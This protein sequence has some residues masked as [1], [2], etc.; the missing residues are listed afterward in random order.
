MLRGPF[1]CATW[2][3]RQAGCALSWLQKLLVPCFRNLSALQPGFW[4]DYHQIP[5]LHTHAPRRIWPMMAPSRQNRMTEWTGWWL[6]FGPGGPRMYICLLWWMLYL[7]YRTQLRP[8]APVRTRPRC[9]TPGQLGPGASLS[10]PRS[11][12]SFPNTA[13]PPTH[14]VALILLFLRQH[15]T[16]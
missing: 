1:A 13:L 11:E 9:V 7:P 6:T 15:P 10:P 4:Y 8:Q 12:R 14:V 3:A 16:Q 2:A 5:A